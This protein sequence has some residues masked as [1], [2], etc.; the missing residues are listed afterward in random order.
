MESQVTL[1]AELDNLKQGNDRYLELLQR[2]V[3]DGN[4]MNMVDNHQKSISLQYKTS[5]A[6]DVRL[7]ECGDW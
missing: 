7:P 1:T 2:K 6:D 3:Q 4:I 5:H